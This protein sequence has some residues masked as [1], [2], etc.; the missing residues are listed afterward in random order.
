MLTA[1][2]LFKMLSMK[3]LLHTAL[4]G[5]RITN[6]FLQGVPTEVTLYSSSTAYTSPDMLHMCKACFRLSETRHM[7]LLQPLSP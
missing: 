7:L 1:V 3:P 4:V 6:M 5:K 2:R